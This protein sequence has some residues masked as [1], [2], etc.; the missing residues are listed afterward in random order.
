MV[1]LYIKKRSFKKC[2][3][4]ARDIQLIQYSNSRY[5]GG[6]YFGKVPLS[7]RK[8][9]DRAL[10]AGVVKRHIGDMVVDVLKKDPKPYAY[11]DIWKVIHGP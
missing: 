9:L 1:N 7:R 4:C 2:S 11:A 10:R 6:H 8:E 3:I 5:R